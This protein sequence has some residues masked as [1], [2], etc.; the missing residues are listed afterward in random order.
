MVHTVPLNDVREHDLTTTCDCG[1]AVFWKHPDTGEP[2]SQAHVV[3]HSYDGRE[4]IEEAEDIVNAE[5][6]T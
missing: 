5:I 6:H 2:F 4:F 3:H 1:P